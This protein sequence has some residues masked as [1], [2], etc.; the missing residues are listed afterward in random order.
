MDHSIH[1]ESLVPALILADFIYVHLST[2]KTD[3]L[4]SAGL[5]L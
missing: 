1:V 2:Y 3:L 5:V 4:K